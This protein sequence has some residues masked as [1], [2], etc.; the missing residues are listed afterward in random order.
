MRHLTLKLIV[1]F[2]LATCLFAC[3]P[4]S[5]V[6][7]T[8]TMQSQGGAFTSA[9]S[10]SGK[11]SVVSSLY[12]GVSLWDL[13]Q[14]G[15]KYVWDQGADV[16]LSFADGTQ[17]ATIKDDNFVFAAA[18]S[19]DDSHALLADKTSFSLWNIDSG[20]NLGYW[21]IHSATVRPVNSTESNLW[22]RKYGTEG[23]EEFEVVNANQCLQPDLSK[24]ERCKLL[25][26]LR[27][28][29]VSNQ[30][31]HIL[32][33]KSNGIAVHINV[34]TGRRLE[35]LG[36]Q[37][38]VT[39]DNGEPIKINNAINS[40]ALSPNGKFALTGS[41]DNIAYLWDS[42]TGQ[43][44]YKFRHSSRV[45]QVALD[46]K[47]RY[48]FTSDSKKQS[49]IW[50]LK[51]GKKLSNLRFINRQEIFSFARF[52]ANGKWLVTGAPTRQLTLW[53]VETGKQLKQ[54]LVTPREGSRPA[55]AVVYS[56]AFINEQELISASSSGLIET[57]D[58]TH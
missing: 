4:Q 58:L 6:P 12:H 42:K 57:W 21:K 43:V 29:D 51:T 8:Q 35:F 11:Y 2:A 32:L 33:G 13:Q 44:I 28:I 24:G 30:G 53:D 17:T 46:P 16:N 41:S 15:L 34:N 25:S 19:Y 56:A 38:E 22:Q 31:K 50:D 52:S 9:I 1:C 45:I 14:Q 36:H 26:R 18:I 20:K 5:S 39:G 10:Y 55:S 54:W 40:V 23:N 49:N 37:T 3:Q 27:A 48:A 7:L 47:G